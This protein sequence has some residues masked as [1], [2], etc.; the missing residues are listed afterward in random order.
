MDR[1]NPP[2]TATGSAVQMPVAD[3][4]IAQAQPATCSNVH[5]AFE[6]IGN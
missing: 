3:K 6:V 1:I 2:I 5:V 4:C